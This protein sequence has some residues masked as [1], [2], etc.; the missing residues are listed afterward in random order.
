MLDPPSIII[1]NNENDNDPWIECRDLFEPNRSYL[2]QST[3]SDNNYS[4]R[5]SFRHSSVHASL[6][7]SNCIDMFNNKTHCPN[8]DSN[9]DDVHSIIEHAELTYGT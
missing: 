3:T 4:Q 6:N 9:Y 5:Y 2:W 7:E 1:D 8:L